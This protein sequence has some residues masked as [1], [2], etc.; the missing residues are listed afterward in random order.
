MLFRLIGN[1]QLLFAQISQLG[2]P[3]SYPNHP[4]LNS[5]P[6]LTISAIGQADDTALFSNN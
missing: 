6:Q 5:I 1:D 4:N 2:V 3:L